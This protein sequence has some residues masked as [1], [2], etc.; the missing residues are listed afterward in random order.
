MTQSAG[1]S[2][3]AFDA[4]VLVR[5][6]VGDDPAQTKKAERAFVAHANDGGI[7]VSMVV[8][9]E[10]AWVLTAAY[11]WD[12]T[13]IHE[14]LVRLLRTRGVTI[15]QLELVA[16]ALDEYAAGKADLADYLIVGTARSAADG[17]LTFDKRLARETGVTLL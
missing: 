13:M 17:L 1:P 12:R 8:L 11:A 9:A 4:N 6:L 3:I 2:V 16:R 14:R 15:E 7:F 10:V 5:V